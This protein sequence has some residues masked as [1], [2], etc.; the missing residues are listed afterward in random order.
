M[1]KGIIFDFDGVLADSIIPAF[2]VHKRM[3]A[4]F[5]KNH[6]FSLEEFKKMGNTDWKTMYRSWGFSDQEMDKLPPVFNEAFKEL[7]H[8]IK[9]FEGT[10]RMLNS[11]HKRFKLAIV[12]NSNKLR[13]EEH[14]QEEGLAH[15]FDVIIDGF[16]TGKIKPDPYQI[17]L[18]MEQLGI[19]A[20]NAVFVGDTQEDITA[21][22][23]AKVAKIVAVTYGYQHPERLAGA[24][25]YASSPA[26][27]LEV[28]EDLL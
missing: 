25:F 16:E 23:S 18:C 13:I 3:L 2:K 4:V 8:E 9:M 26:E 1:I 14:L 22:R 24:D 5:G 7:R 10:E 17:L 11:L 6:D 21:G 27:L 28:L 12:S 19:S 20:E 15:Y